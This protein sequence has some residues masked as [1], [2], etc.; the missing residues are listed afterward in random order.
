MESRNFRNP[1]DSLKITV[2]NLQASGL[3]FLRYA[4]V[5][6][7]RFYDQS[8]RNSWIT[9]R[10]SRRCRREADRNGDVKV[11]QQNERRKTMCEGEVGGGGGGIRFYEGIRSTPSIPRISRWPGSGK[12]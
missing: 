11:Y 5:N 4:R 3:K 9:A 1:E 12:R 8:I 6:E 2:T 7:C 10:G